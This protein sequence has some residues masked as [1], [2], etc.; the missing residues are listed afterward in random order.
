MAIQTKRR[1]ECLSCDERLDEVAGIVARAVLR[2]A[3]LSRKADL[4]ER[5][6]LGFSVD[7]SVHADVLNRQ[8]TQP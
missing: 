1:P 5:V 7:K 8:D 6:G 3:E 4:G 2:L